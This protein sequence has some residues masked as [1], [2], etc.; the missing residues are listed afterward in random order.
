M[1]NQI[2]M[3]HSV[4]YKYCMKV[5][6]VLLVKM[7][8]TCCRACPPH[9]YAH[10]G[11]VLTQPQAPTEADGRMVHQQLWPLVSPF[12][13]GRGR[14]GEEQGGGWEELAGR[15]WDLAMASTARSSSQRWLR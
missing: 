10:I 9:I 7:L 2:I 13:V 11:A 3:E 8:Q 14:E 12:G 4:D 1:G 5:M 15:G 6:A